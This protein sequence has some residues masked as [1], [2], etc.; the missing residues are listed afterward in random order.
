[1]KASQRT[2]LLAAVLLVVA[3]VAAAAVWRYG[4]VTPIERCSRI[5]DQRAR[6]DCRVA[7]VDADGVSVE[8]AMAIIDQVESPESRDIV[9]LRLVV[10]D[11]TIARE[12]CPEMEGA[13]ARE[14]CTRI[15]KR[16]HL[17]TA[18]PE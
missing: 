11:P 7:I 15:V 10:R 3:L 13:K 4:M 14:W 6:D 2:G 12:T 1:M 16:P 17:S 9:R 8:E 5:D 18:V